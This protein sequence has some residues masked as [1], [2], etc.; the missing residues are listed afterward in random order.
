MGVEP[1][2]VPGSKIRMAAAAE[3]SLPNWLGETWLSSGGAKPKLFV[4]MEAALKW[5][6]AAE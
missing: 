3:L 6:G 4:E 1:A 5:L 2:R